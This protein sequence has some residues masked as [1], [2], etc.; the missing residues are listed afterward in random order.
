[1]SLLLIFVFFISDERRGFG[2]LCHG[3]ISRISKY[4]VRVRHISRYIINKIY[5]WL[6]ASFSL[7]FIM[8][9]FMRRPWAPVLI[10]SHAKNLTQGVFSSQKFST[11]NITSN[12]ATYA[13]SIKCRRNKKIIAQF[14]VKSRD[15]SFKPN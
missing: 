3:P 6:V 1:M 4:C 15:K 5:I 2:P 9:G 12:L 8:I 14:T 7:L 10:T 13:W 11:Q